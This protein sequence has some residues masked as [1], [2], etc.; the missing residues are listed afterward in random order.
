MA[1]R[2]QSC[3]P[4]QAASRAARVTAA[5]RLRDTAATMSQENV[6]LVRRWLWAFQSD[7]DAFREIVHPEIEWSPFEEDHTP[8]HGVEAA[9]RIRNQWIETWDEHRVD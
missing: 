5:L 1:T 7:T 3:L 8:S 4:S 2:S 6:E 9:M